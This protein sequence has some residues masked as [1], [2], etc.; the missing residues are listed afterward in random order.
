MKTQHLSTELN[1]HTEFFYLNTET[2]QHFLSRNIKTFNYLDKDIISNGSTHEEKTL[3]IVCSGKVRVLRPMLNSDK[4]VSY[5]LDIGCIFGIEDIIGSGECP[6]IVSAVGD[7][8][9][10]S[11][12]KEDILEQLKHT[13]AL[14]GLFNH[15]IRT[16]NHVI[17]P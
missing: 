2:N 17:N 12:H 7:T 3:N 16:M 9:I 1:L 4:I 10:Y 15:Y 14:M 5:D 6:L 13:H 8:I 11:I